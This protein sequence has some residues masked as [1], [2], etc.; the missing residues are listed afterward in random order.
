M[1]RERDGAVATC[2][3]DG[4]WHQHVKSVKDL[5]YILGNILAGC[6][7]ESVFIGQ[8]YMHKEFGF[9]RTVNS[10]YSTNRRVVVYI[11]KTN[12]YW[13]ILYNRDNNIHLGTST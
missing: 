6:L 3:P 13:H 12:Q 7:S 11:Q 1:E 5:A 2:G 9:C 10:T 4:C 8:V